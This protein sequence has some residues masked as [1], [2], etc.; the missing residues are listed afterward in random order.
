M[1]NGT[2]EKMLSPDSFSLG[3]VWWSDTN[4]TT[5][6]VVSCGQDSQDTKHITQY[7]QSYQLL[8]SSADFINSS[9]TAISAFPS[10]QGTDMTNC[11]E[12]LGL[13]R[14]YHCFPLIAFPYL[15]ANHANA[16]ARYEGFSIA[17]GTQYSAA[18]EIFSPPPYNTRICRCQPNT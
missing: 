5:P 1:E 13:C 12:K 3:K 6:P 10:Q 11:P 18:T 2:T 4:R 7:V 8:S 17:M 9:S 16:C 15:H 14:I